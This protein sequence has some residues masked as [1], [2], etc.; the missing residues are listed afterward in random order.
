MLQAPSFEQVYAWR[1][2]QEEKLRQ[3]RQEARGSDL[4]G[5]MSTAQL[6]RFIQH[7]ERLTRHSLATLPASADLVFSLNQAH[8]VVA[9]VNRL[10]A[11]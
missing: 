8:R 2:L 3:S 4:S 7:F 5:I 11:P 6:S 10:G 9:Q 1:G